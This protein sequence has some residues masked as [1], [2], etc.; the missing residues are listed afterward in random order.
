MARGWDAAGDGGGPGS[1]VKDWQAKTRSPGS[2][3]DWAWRGTGTQAGA[4]RLQPHTGNEPDSDLTSASGAAG[5]TSA[6][7]GSGLSDSD[8][9]LSRRMLKS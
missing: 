2:L 5:T 7:W 8:S 9:A 1:V 4:L 3:P 6:N